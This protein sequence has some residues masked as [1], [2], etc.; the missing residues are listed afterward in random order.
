MSEKVRLDQALTMRSRLLGRTSGE[1]KGS[2]FQKVM[3]GRIQLSNDDLGSVRKKLFSLTPI[4]VSIGKQPPR[5]FESIQNFERD[6][7]AGHES[8]EQHF[9]NSID[10]YEKIIEANASKKVSI[11]GREMTVAFAIIYRDVFLPRKKEVLEKLKYDLNQALTQADMIDR[12][13]MDKLNEIVHA[14]ASSE[15][16]TDPAK[17]KSAEEVFMES[18]R[19]KVHDPLELRNL[20]K[21]MEAEIENEESDLKTALYTNNIGTEIEW[22]PSEK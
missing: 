2:I 13:A 12:Q 16:K 5:G 3:N 22:T 15:K 7:K 17:M 18:R 6:V 8:F 11:N 1:F 14:D 10:L 20:V 9:K 4:S 21:K 19:A